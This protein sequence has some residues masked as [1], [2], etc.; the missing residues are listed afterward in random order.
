MSDIPARFPPPLMRSKVVAGERVP[1]VERP[2][3]E[4][5]QEVRLRGKLV[6]CIRRAGHPVF[7]NYGHTNGYDEW[8][9]DALEGGE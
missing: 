9:F 4:C 2:F 5:G 1:I 6:V 7:I 3:V 8:C